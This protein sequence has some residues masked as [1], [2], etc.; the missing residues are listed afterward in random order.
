MPLYLL[1]IRAL[2]CPLLLSIKDSNCIHIFTMICNSS[3]LSWQ[4]QNYIL[5][6]ATL[7]FSQVPTGHNFSK[8]L[9]EPLLPRCSLPNIL[10]LLVCKAAMSS[11]EP[12][13]CESQVGVQNPALLASI[14]GVQGA[15]LLG[16]LWDTN[17]SLFSQ[18]DR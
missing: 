9:L 8:S 18:F 7:A 1:T 5:L 15:L 4:A 6:H 2:S 14:V 10:I 17:H 3:F 16:F 12:Q 11:N 13:I